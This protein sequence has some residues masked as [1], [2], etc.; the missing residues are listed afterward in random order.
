M[1]EILSLWLPVV[2]SSIFV[3]IASSVIHMALPWH[4]NDYPKLAMEEKLMDALRPLNL[5]RGDFMVPRANDMKEMRSPEFTEKLKKGPVLILTVLPNGMSS[6]GRSLFLWFL[7]SVVISIFTAYVLG[8]S[9]MIGETYFH[10]FRIACAV[11]FLGYAAGLWQMSIWYRRSWSITLK[12][13]FDGLIYAL[14]TA[15]T[16]G[17]LWPHGA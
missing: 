1:I 13:T 16:F 10:V 8:R 5:P 4:K 17:R 6:M 12:S 15:G 3:F 14:V 7:N 9:F 11:S 2:L